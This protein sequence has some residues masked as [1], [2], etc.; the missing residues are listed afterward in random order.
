MVQVRRA[1]APDAAVRQVEARAGYCGEI[2][3]RKPLY[4]YIFGKAEE[5]ESQ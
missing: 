3:F 1:A 5:K 4:I 2:F